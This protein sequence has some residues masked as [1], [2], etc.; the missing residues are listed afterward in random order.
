[1]AMPCI[2]LIEGAE[3]EQ[4]QLFLQKQTQQ[5]YNAV[6]TTIGRTGIGRHHHHHGAKEQ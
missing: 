2:D 3:T 6:T 1:M 5:L 4:E